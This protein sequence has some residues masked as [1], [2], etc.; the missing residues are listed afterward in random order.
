MNLVGALATA[1]ATLGAASIKEMQKVALAI[2]PSLLTEGK[3]FQKA[4]QLGMY[5]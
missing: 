1:M 3:V 4:Q 5:K 2:A